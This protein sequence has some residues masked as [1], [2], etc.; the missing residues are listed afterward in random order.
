MRINKR[1][2]EY[3]AFLSPKNEA[4]VTKSLMRKLSMPGMLLEALNFII[5]SM[6]KS[7]KTVVGS[8][9]NI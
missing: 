2:E 1:N 4:D 5:N 9:F 7:I 6:A 3:Y 8:T